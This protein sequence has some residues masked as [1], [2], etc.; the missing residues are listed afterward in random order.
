MI[1]KCFIFMIVCSA[2]YAAHADTK[3]VLA[4]IGNRFDLERDIQFSD[5]TAF[6]GQ[7]LVASNQDSAAHNTA[8][9]N[10]ACAQVGVTIFDPL[11]ISGKTFYFAP[12]LIIP[13]KQGGAILTGGGMH[14]DMDESWRGGGLIGS[15]TTLV[16][17]GGSTA[18]PCIDYQGVYWEFGPMNIYAFPISN[19]TDFT[20][21]R[22][23]HAVDGGHPDGYAY[24]PRRDVGLQISKVYLDPDF[25]NGRLRS[26]GMYFV[27][28]HRAVNIASTPYNS[29]CD[30]N[31]WDMLGMELCDYGIY[32]EANLQSIDNHIHRLIVGSPC[33]HPLH[34]E[35]GD[36]SVDIVDVEGTCQALLY[37]GSEENDGWFDIR[38]VRVDNGPIPGVKLI[39]LS[40]DTNT[41]V[42]ISI[43]GYYNLKEYTGVDGSHGNSDDYPDDTLA[44]PCVILNGHTSGHFTIHLDMQGISPTTAALYPR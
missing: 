19:G 18:T 5:A 3:V 34:F 16:F 4:R 1:R 35:R 22:T 14:Y 17:V 20:N 9:F 37:T 41:R 44:S 11:Y 38:R 24:G 15:V 33:T 28:F 23:P 39:E 32:D 2:A 6:S 12:G 26:H 21:A 42:H 43:A 31:D 13:A 27:G 25:A 30:K 10:Y 29:H 40:S 8:V 7:G 36:C